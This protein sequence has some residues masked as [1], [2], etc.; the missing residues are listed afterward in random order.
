MHLKTGVKKIRRCIGGKGGTINREKQK[1]GERE[2]HLIEPGMRNR[3][4]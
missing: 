1:M 2:D 4:R 3:V